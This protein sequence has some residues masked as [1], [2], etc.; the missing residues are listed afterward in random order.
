MRLIINRRVTHRRLLAV[1]TT[2]KVRAISKISGLNYRWL[3]KL[4]LLTSFL[5]VVASTELVRAQT[6]SEWF[7]Q[8][9]T[10]KKYLLAQIAALKTYAI[11][12]EKGYHMAQ[13]GL[14]TIS[15]LKE[16]NFLQHALHFNTM[17]MVSP[18]V[19]NNPRVAAIA[20]MEDGSA[21]VR[22]RLMVRKDLNQWLTSKENSSLKAFHEQTTKE[23]AKDLDYLELLVTDNTLQMTTAER[24]QQIETLYAAVK[25]KYSSV[26]LFARHTTALI[27]N[28]KRQAVESQL[29]KQLYGK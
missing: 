20:T 10:Q 23:A 28:R 16:S 18:A 19:K 6:F 9:K 12:L 13:S 4:L 22:R 27:Q 17:T 24:I 15:N 11:A 8:K 14:G 7:K 2:T 29:L 3:L 25:G 5:L 21:G 1:I 26:L